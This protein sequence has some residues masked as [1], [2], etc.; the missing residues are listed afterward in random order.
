MV[1]RPLIAE[2]L[3][4]ARVEALRHE[5]GESPRRT[6]LRRRRVWRLALGARLVRAGHRLIDT[7]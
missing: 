7:A 3:A 4:R 6:R 2:E 1:L 5:G